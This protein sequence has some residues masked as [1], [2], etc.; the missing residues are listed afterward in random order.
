M[1]DQNT[2]VYRKPGGDEMV[3]ASGGKITIQAGGVI[4]LPTTDP[5]VA[6][7]LWNSAGTITVSA[8]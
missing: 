1:A 8:G 3:V 4:I 2:K 6:G 7:A 5:H